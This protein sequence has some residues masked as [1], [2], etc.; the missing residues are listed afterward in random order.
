MATESVV[1]DVRE[2]KLVTLKEQRPRS[3]SPWETAVRHLL[4]DKLTMVGIIALL[5]LTLA[6]LFAP[7]FFEQTLGVNSNRTDILNRYKVP[8][9]GNNILGTDQLGRD[10]LVRLL[11]GGRVSLGVAYGASIMSISIGLVIGMIAGYYSGWID[12]F[13][14]WFITTLSSIPQLFLLILISVILTPSPEVLIVLLGVL[15]WITTC[16][17]VRSEVRALKEREFVIAA[18]ALGAPTWRLLFTH[19]LPNIVSLVIISLTIDAGQL[20]LTESALSFLGLGVRP[21]TPSWGNMLTEARKYFST[22]THLVVWPGIMIVIT[23]L[24]FFVVGD[25]LRDALDP[26]TAKQK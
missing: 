17:L 24:C 22:G 13:V 26:R 19:L 7:P 15:G 6:C 12:D 21:P 20:I 10:Q 9:T 14:N 5:V 23:V 2:V 4:R 16:R 8:G 3:R 18:R 1:N 11:Y 25:G